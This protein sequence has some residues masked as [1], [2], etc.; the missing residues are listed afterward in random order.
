MCKQVRKCEIIDYVEKIK[1]KVPEKECRKIKKPR[2]V[3]ITITVE[4]PSI[5]RT[6]QL[7]I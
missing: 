6:H 1:K 3:C 5:V 2:K 4:S 7:S